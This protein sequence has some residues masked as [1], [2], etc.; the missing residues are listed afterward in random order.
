[1]MFGRGTKKVGRPD[2]GAEWHSDVSFPETVGGQ[3]VLHGWYERGWTLTDTDAQFCFLTYRNTF[4]G[5]FDLTPYRLQDMGI[6]K[7]DCTITPHR[8]GYRADI[9]FFGVEDGC[10]RHRA[11]RVIEAVEIG[12]FPGSLDQ[13]ESAARDM[14]P[15][16]LAM[17][18]LFGDCS[19]NIIQAA[20]PWVAPDATPTE[21]TPA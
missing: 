4:D 10:R 18:F 21:D 8:V 1:M 3:A 16:A 17:C 20:A 6:R 11:I 2:V 19:D 7:L 5:R 15:T 14:D 9:E 12:S 13:A